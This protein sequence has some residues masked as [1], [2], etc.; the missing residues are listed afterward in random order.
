M[1]S[2]GRRLHEV[3]LG[4]IQIA[5]GETIRQLVQE[6]SETAQG[7]RFS[8]HFLITE[9]EKVI[10]GWQLD[11]WEAYRA[12]TRL[13][14]KTRLKEPQRAELWSIVEDVRSRLRSKS[15]ITYSGLF[16]QLAAHFEGS[17]RSPFDFVVVDEAQD[18]SI[19]QLRFLA[20]LGAGRPN[21]LFF[22][23]DLGQRI[24]QQPFTKRT[25]TGP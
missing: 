15:L 3:N 6:A 9:W 17:V 11:T 4:K 25:K 16:N 8:I 14:R 5:S 7:N 18:V 1:N 24:F 19:A 23:G 12:V 21:K 20:A 2:I 13:G 22:A 10:D